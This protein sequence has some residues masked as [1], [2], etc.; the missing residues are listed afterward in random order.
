MKYSAWPIVDAQLAD[1]N[2]AWWVNGFHKAHPE[3][4]ETLQTAR[5]GTQAP[6]ADSGEGQDLFSTWS[7]SFCV[8]CL[9]FWNLNVFQSSSYL[10]T[11]KAPPSPVH[12]SHNH[13]SNWSSTLKE[14]PKNRNKTGM[15]RAGLEFLSIRNFFWNFWML[16]R[17]IRW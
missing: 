15:I 10:V 17:K 3:I 12:K 8:V 5:A 14:I 6:P 9:G 13:K 11:V 7:Q 2:R 1:W 16:T 4:R